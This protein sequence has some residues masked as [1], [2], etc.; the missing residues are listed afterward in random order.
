[1][2]GGNS[3]VLRLKTIFQNILDLEF[4]SSC[5]FF[6]ISFFLSL[7]FCIL[8]FFFFFQCICFTELFFV[9]FD[10][11]PT[12]Q[13]LRLGC[14]LPPAS[15]C[16]PWV[17]RTLAMQTQPPCFTFTASLSLRLCTQIASVAAIL[18][19]WIHQVCL[20]AVL[21][22]WPQRD[23]CLGLCPSCPY[24]NI[25]GKDHGAHSVASIFSAAFA[26]KQEAFSALLYM[27]TS[28]RWDDWRGGG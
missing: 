25:S 14:V 11:V 4:I 8:V 22:N 12:F 7:I 27:G 3:T 19:W 21:Y 10:N 2:E 18:K 13:L 5:R 17:L 20:I 1:M 9:L 6:K 15:E 26:Q 16:V 24:Q 23:V 28:P